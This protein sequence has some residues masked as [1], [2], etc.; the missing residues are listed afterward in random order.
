MKK[1]FLLLSGIMAACCLYGSYRAMLHSATGLLGHQKVDSIKAITFSDATLK[2]TEASG[3]ETFNREDISYLKFAND[4]VD[5]YYNGTTAT[6]ENPLSEYGLN[7]AT[8][9]AQ[10]TVTAD[11]TFDLKDVVFKLS[12]TTTSGGLT[13]QPQKR[14]TLF[15]DGVNLTNPN[16]AAISVTQDQNVT[17]NIAD[18]T[19][20]TLTDGG[21]DTT[22]NAALWSAGQLT[23]DG[24]GTLN[25]T[26]NNNHGICSKDYIKINNG[27]I[28]ITSASDALHTNDY[29]TLNGGTVVVD[30]SN[31]GDGIDAADSV[32]VNGGSLTINVS[33][34]D[35]RA[36]KS[37]GNIT[38]NNCEQMNLNLTGD[39]TRGIKSGTYLAASG[40]SVA[41]NIAI[42]GGT[43]NITMTEVL[44]YDEDGVN[45]SKGAGIKSDSL[46]D[47]TGGNIQINIDEN[48]KG[49]KGVNADSAIYLHGT[50]TIWVSNLCLKG[51]SQ[52]YKSD[53]AIYQTGTDVRG[54]VNASNGKADTKVY[55]P[56][57]TQITE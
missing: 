47:I 52:C 54:E 25:V 31:K 33:A 57:P 20:N 8:D 37:D 23:F 56:D 40:D 51:K 32:T 22:Y 18:G 46:I 43:I 14:F 45:E 50:A 2:F 34:D 30:T 12:G 10:V 49:V 28:N 19:T 16:S 42:K 4:T 35:M 39:G 13:I 6:I 11:T 26:G 53:G 29:V 9:G 15:L 55:S 3:V 5:I 21:A 41:G 7:V 17:V 24:N 1:T 44:V 38:I 27:V 48:S 36:I